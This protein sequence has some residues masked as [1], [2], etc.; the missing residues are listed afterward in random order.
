MKSEAKSS[1]YFFLFEPGAAEFVNQNAAESSAVFQ[2]ANQVNKRKSLC[3]RLAQWAYATWASFRK[4][5]DLNLIS[6]E[7]ADWCRDVLSVANS[8]EELEFLL[9]ASFR[10]GCCGTEEK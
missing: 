6:A 9:F 8:P 7:V 5:R 3:F 4:R 10:R 2:R 1:L